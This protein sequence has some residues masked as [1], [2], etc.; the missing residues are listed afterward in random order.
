MVMFLTY[1]GAFT[2]VLKVLLWTTWIFFLFVLD[3]LLHTEASY[4]IAV[5]IM[6][7]YNN[8][9]LRILLRGPMRGRNKL[10]IALS[11]FAAGIVSC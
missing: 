6:V 10:I 11:L 3:A 2:I 5:V 7:L 8:L 9:L 4:S 1:H